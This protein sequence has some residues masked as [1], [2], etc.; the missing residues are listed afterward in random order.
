MKGLWHCTRL[1]L[2]SGNGGD[3]DVNQPIGYLKNEYLF[4]KF[5]DELT[6][7]TK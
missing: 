3:S 1:G 2:K 6:T 7:H 4:T 5:C